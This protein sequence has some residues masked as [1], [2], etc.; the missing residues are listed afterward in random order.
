MEAA[1]LA[2]IGYEGPYSSKVSTQEGGEKLP[3]TKKWGGG[4]LL[5]HFWRCCLIFSAV[6]V[7]N[8]PVLYHKINHFCI[9]QAIG[10]L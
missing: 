6:Y 7:V 1:R 2:Y 3:I 5:A 10:S 8:I 9:I 4:G